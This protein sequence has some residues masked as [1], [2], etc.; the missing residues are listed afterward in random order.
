MAEAK[1]LKN[2]ATNE[3]R[4]NA[5]SERNVRVSV[6]LDLSVFHPCSIRGSGFGEAGANF[7]R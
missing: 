2:E 5:S 1:P 3:T 7:E 6:N 4:K